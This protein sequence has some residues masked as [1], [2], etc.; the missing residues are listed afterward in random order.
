MISIVIPVYNSEKSL[1]KLILNTIE[2]FKDLSFEIIL[3]NDCS[4]DTSHKKCLELCDKFDTLISYI[5]LSKNVGEH[6]A[7]MA[8]L[9]ITV[10][11]WVVIMDDDFQ[12][13]PLEALKL[14]N[15]ASKSNFQ[16]VY[17]KYNVKMHSFFRN[18]GSKINDLT[19]NL[20][21]R[22]PKDLYLSS[23]KCIKKDLV[24]KIIDYKGPYTYIDG[25]ILSIT[26]NFGTLNID[27]NSRTFGRSQYS[28]K[29]LIKLYFNI[30]TN[31]S[32]FPIHLFSIIGFIVATISSIYGIFI[33]VE[34]FINPDIPAGYSSILTAIVFFSGIQLIF[35]GL[36][37]EYVGKILKNVNQEPQYT[38]EFKKLKNEKK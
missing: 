22:K 34:K 6:N 3:V 38:I 20:I 29:K 11:D 8:G 37:G 25:L 31:F 7:V 16:V 23:F 1:K 10:G 5:K 12:H 4:T 14:I 15:Y 27:H 17:G 9:R 18:L 28:L 24:K 36:I 2:V 35:L 19:T 32:T 26:S 21:L 33:I 30:A 13:P